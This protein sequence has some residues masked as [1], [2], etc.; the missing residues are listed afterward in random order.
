MKKILNSLLALTLLVALFTFTSCESDDDEPNKPYVGEW[1]SAVYPLRHPV[2]GDTVGWEK[3]VF[4]FTN[5]TFEDAIYQ[6]Q[7]ADAVVS[8]LSMGGDIANPAEGEL[9]ADI[10]ILTV[11]GTAIKKATQPDLFETT[12]NTFLAERLDQSFDATYTIDGETMVLTIPIKNPV[13]EGY[14]ET[15][16]TLTKK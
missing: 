12:F 15:P 5:T 1:E 16:L 13:G 3:M 2:S 6:G 14:I 4:T 10:N 7:T 8:N 11:Q 9:E